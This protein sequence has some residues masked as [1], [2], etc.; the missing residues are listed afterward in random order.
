MEC[1]LEPGDILYIP[2]CWWHNVI[3]LSPSISINV[4]YKHL[5]DEAYTKKDL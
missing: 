5:D 2:S 3:T 4:F 1:V